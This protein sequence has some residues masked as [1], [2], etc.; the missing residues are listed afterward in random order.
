MYL[1]Y[2]RKTEDEAERLLGFGLFAWLI[3]LAYSIAWLIRSQLSFLEG[4]TV[5]VEKLTY[6]WGLFPSIK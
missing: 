3:R 5:F 1:P 2:A 6:P 4:R